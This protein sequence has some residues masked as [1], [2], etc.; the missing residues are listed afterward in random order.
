MTTRVGIAPPAGEKKHPRPRDPSKRKGACCPRLFVH[1]ELDRI[2]SP[3]PYF[4]V[5]KKQASSTPSLGSLS[6]S[7]FQLI[8][9]RP[10]SQPATNAQTLL[11]APPNQNSNRTSTETGNH[12]LQGDKVSTSTPIY[13]QGWCTCLVSTVRPV[14]FAI[15]GSKGTLN[16]SPPASSPCVIALFPLPPSLSGSGSRSGSGFR[17]GSLALHT[18]PH[19]T[20]SIHP[21]FHIA[22][23]VVALIAWA[24]S[25]LR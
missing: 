19:H 7:R 15:L 3:R 17:C 6:S 23:K 13:G 11:T 12:H 14:Q 4:P 10:A 18:A 20:T 21:P 25:I 9:S 16:R 1:E 22:P 8:I 5:P 2:L 24:S